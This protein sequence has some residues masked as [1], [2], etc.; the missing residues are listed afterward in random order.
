MADMLPPVLLVGCGNMG[1]AMLDGWLKEGLAPSF[2]IDR[3]RPSVPAPHHLVRSADEVPDSFHPGMIVLATKPQ[4]VDAVMSA[5][6]PFALR[7]PVL[8]VL[9][10][11]RSGDLA[12]R[13]TD[14]LPAGS[15]MPVVIRAM[16]NT[17]S[18]IGQGMSVCY[19]LPAATPT[20][21]A[22]CTR[23][24]RAVGD[25]AWI[26]HEDQMDVVTAISGSGPAYVFLL[27]E[28][29]EE[30]GVAQGLPPALARQIARQTVAGAGALMIQGGMDAATLR[31]NVTSPGGT[32]QQAL[33]VLMAPD[34][35]PA[36]LA[37]A[38][39][40]AARRS[41]ELSGASPVS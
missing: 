34:A 9:A 25:V 36:A 5:I 23:L 29:L 12:D 32:T 41:R 17:P 40:A 21:R 3:H 4:K 24:L 37:T 8:S 35:W 27:A 6:A 30:T 15:P 11:R 31:R 1:G 19:A 39:R 2:I 7:A 18:S 38:V 14:A 10:G 22:L 20:Q 33:E 26:D 28:L 16:P 13:L